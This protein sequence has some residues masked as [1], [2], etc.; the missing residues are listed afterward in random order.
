[1]KTTS[2]L[3]A[4]VAVT[5]AT[6]ARADASKW[7]TPEQ[8]AACTKHCD[9]YSD[10]RETATPEC[11]AELDRRT[12]ACL[13]DPKEKADFDAWVKSYKDAKSTAKLPTF[14]ENCNNDV[15]LDMESAMNKYED[16]CKQKKEDDA[17]K[18]KLESTEV[19]K[20]AMHDAKLEAMIKKAYEKDYHGEN[21]VLKVVLEGW[22]DDYEKDAFGRITGRDMLATVV[23]KQPDG[24]CSLHSELFL[25]Q[26]N[27]RSFSGPF[28]LRGAGSA[29][30]D[31]ILCSKVE[32]KAA[33]TPAKT[34]VKKQGK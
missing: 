29:S 26:G 31:E 34:P 28:T 8:A 20:A 25:Q 4:L 30:D 18:A 7:G 17:A 5:T 14:E 13:A 3:A 27:G 1:M 21:K 24:K 22:D 6:A 15:K 33:A 11:K 10:W 9:Y 32:G 2:I 19:P 23:N 12:K 16:I